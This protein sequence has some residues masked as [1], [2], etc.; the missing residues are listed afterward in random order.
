MQTK[1]LLSFN[2]L[3]CLLTGCMA[4]IAIG[5]NCYNTSGVQQFGGYTATANKFDG[6]TQATSPYYEF[7]YFTHYA[8]FKRWD[9]SWDHDHQASVVCHK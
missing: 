9:N 7:R 5:Q 4:V 1:K 6:I 2:V 3:L 8:C